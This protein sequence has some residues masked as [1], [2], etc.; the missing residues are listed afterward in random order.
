MCE[1]QLCRKQ[2][3]IREVRKYL[4]LKSKEKP[5][6]IDLRCGFGWLTHE[7]SKYGAIVGVDLSA[8]AARTLYPNLKFIETNII[9]DKI[10]E[11]Y[12]IVVSSEVIE[13]LAQ[14]DQLIYI[15][16]VY[17][18]LTKGGILIMTTPNKPVVERLLIKNYI[19][20]GDLQP[21]EN[22]LNKESLRTLLSPYFEISFMG[23]TMF[24]PDFTRNNRYIDLAYYFIH[25]RIVKS[26]KLVNNII[27]SSIKGLYMTIVASKR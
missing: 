27:G 14:K 20:R 17:D 4:K 24:R 8:D 19:T 22:W 16:K 2:F 5:R 25:I 18:L 13:H 15:S 1:D 3:I 9:E 10:E 23:T 11:K 26:Y 6:L 12:N 21:I 7:L